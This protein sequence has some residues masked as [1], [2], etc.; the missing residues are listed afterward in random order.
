MLHVLSNEMMRQI[1]T[2][3]VVIVITYDIT[4][5]VVVVPMTMSQL[6]NKFMGVLPHPLNM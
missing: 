4:V 2:M 5:L 3:T 6:P 1:Q